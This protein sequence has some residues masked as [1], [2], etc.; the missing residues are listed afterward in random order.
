[1][2]RKRIHVLVILAFCQTMSAA[3]GDKIIQ[4]GHQ[5]EIE[6]HP[7]SKTFI[8]W[9]RILDNSGMEFIASFSNSIQKDTEGK[10]SSNFDYR[11][12]SRNVIILQSFRRDHDPGLYTCASLYKGKELKFGKVTRL[13][14]G[15]SR[16]VH[17]VERKKKPFASHFDRNVCCQRK[18]QRQN[19]PSLSLFC[20]PL[21]LGP[22]AGGCGLLLVL[23]IAT[24]LYCNSKSTTQ[25]ETESE[26]PSFTEPSL[27]FPL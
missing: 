9:F 7:E 15:E 25:R 1:M 13:V 21:I 4:E 17:V 27:T 22:L 19:P 23:L 5:V 12:I 26:R 2:D 16:F 20:T 3:A 10:A 14:A 6:C 11:R 18:P 8:V 24:S